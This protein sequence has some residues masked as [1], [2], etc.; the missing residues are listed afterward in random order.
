[1]VQAPDP[2]LPLEAVRQT[3]PV[4]TRE[5]GQMLKDMLMHPEKYQDEIPDLELAEDDG[6]PSA[7]GIAG[8]E[9]PSPNGDDPAWRAI[10]AARAGR[11]APSAN[12]REPSGTVT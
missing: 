11:A 3:R 12:G 4:L 1:M 6:P 5:M 7:N 10:L 2:S 9:P 8:V